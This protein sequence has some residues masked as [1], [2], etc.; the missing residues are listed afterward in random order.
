[1]PHRS[2][3][4]ATQGFDLDK[5]RERILLLNRW[6][7]VET[8]ALYDD[9]LR[10][11]ERHFH[12]T[13]VLPGPPLTDRELEFVRLRRIASLE[14]FGYGKDEW[15]RWASAMLALKREAEIGTGER[16]PRFG[17]FG[18]DLPKSNWMRDFLELAEC[19]FGS[20]KFK[21]DVDFREYVFP[22]NVN[23]GR[24]EFCVDGNDEDA[25][26]F[27]C[28]RFLGGEANFEYSV[29]H[30]AVIFNEATFC[31]KANF[32]S[33]VF[34]WYAQFHRASFGDDAWFNRARFEAHC[35][36]SSSKF[37][38]CMARFADAQFHCGADFLDAEFSGST[39]LFHNAK[40]TGEVSFIAVRF[41][42]TMAAFPNDETAIFEDV[43]FSGRVDFSG[44]KFWGGRANFSHVTFSGDATFAE[45][46]VSMDSQFCGKQLVEFRFDADFSHVAF[47][48]HTKFNDVTFEGEANFNAIRCDKNFTIGGTV[49][50]RTPN[51]I[52]ATFSEPPR[53]DNTTLPALLLRGNVRGDPRCLLWRTFKIA[54]DA[55]EY[56]RFR[57]LRR[58]A[59]EARDPES[60]M[61]FGG[62]ELAARRFW[63]DRPFRNSARFWFGW[64]YEKVSNYG[65]SVLRPFLAWLVTAFVFWAIFLAIA[66]DTPR[67]RAVL[68]SP[69]PQS[70]VVATFLENL[71]TRYAIA[72][73][74][75]PNGPVQLSDTGKVVEA[76]ILSLRNAVVVDRTDVAQRMYGCLFG[77][78]SGSGGTL[79]LVP[80]SVTLLSMVQ[81]TLSGIFLFFIGLATRNMFRLR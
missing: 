51:F 61:R 23:F 60:E 13:G 12:E 27:Y 2:A 14:R 46:D 31:G 56:A 7:T 50:R 8:L 35:A 1:M 9:G 53:I 28:A 55:N 69:T 29:F 67:S 6:T 37:T 20:H 32:E 48:G 38:G 66:E 36:F 40:F 78:R 4:A 76:A 24:A 72:N 58:I 43:V 47:L 80:P 65:Q 81:T 73:S 25:A 44:S 21:G 68:L 22:A 57:A 17:Y 11:L 49:F 71:E 3:K 39:A 26:T 45:S 62:L 19:D 77:F 59:A 15:N 63:I 18:H 41:L 75:V 42:S 30:R 79:P 34:S 64:L 74:C 52:G 70:G 33:A 16:L 54:A 5:W 10:N